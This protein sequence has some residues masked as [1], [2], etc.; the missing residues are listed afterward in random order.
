MV[1]IEKN[2]KIY[3]KKISKTGKGMEEYFIMD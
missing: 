3:E 1:E 2:Y